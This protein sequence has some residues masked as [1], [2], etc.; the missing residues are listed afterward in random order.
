MA[1]LMTAPW[2]P[3][4]VDWKEWRVPPPANSYVREDDYLAVSVLTSSTTTGLALRYRILTSS[5]QVHDG[6]ES[7]DG[8]SEN[9]LK[10]FIFKLTEGFLLSATASNIGGGLADSVC[11]VVLALQKGSAASSAPHTILAQGFVSNI[12]GVTWPVGLP[13]GPATSTGLPTG[14]A[15]GDL[16]YYD[17]SAWATFAG[18]AVGTKVL[19]ESSAG[20]LSWASGFTPWASLSASPDKP[21]ASPNAMDDEFDAGTLNTTTLW[22]WYDQQTNSVALANSLCCLTST[23]L[24]YYRHPA[25]VQTLPGGNWEFTAKLQLNG[26]LPASGY[27]TFGL[28]ALELSTN[29]MLAFGFLQKYQDT[30]RIGGI[31]FDTISSISAYV[32]PGSYAAPGSSCPIYARIAL[33]G[34]TITCSASADGHN[35]WTAYSQAQTVPFTTAATRIG[36]VAS[37]MN[38]TAPV[39]LAVDWFRRT[40]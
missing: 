31:L 6:A 20:A 35:W 15:A 37:N 12:V 10:T 5:G 30:T 26:Q 38:S 3:P 1:D 28:A 32:D 13:R 27:A 40:A 39:V 11:G 16:V 24:A 4:G 9:S 34:T 19:Q 21:P 25:I 33:S 17:G 36:L 29:K 8:A 18:N 22:S 23:N 14:A 2:W 7:L